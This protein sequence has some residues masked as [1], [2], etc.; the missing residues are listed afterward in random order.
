MTR[1][2]RCTRILEYSN[3]GVRS[4]LAGY[5]A[6]RRAC[7]WVLAR[8]SSSTDRC[9]RC[10]ADRLLRRAVA[11]CS[12]LQVRWRRCSA[13]CWAWRGCAAASSAGRCRSRPARRTRS[14]ATRPSCCSAC[15][16]ARERH[17]AA[18][19]LPAEE[20]RHR[21]VGTE[22]A[23]S[24][25]KAVTVWQAVGVHLGALLREVRVAAVLGEVRRR[26]PAVLRPVQRSSRVQRSDAARWWI[27]A[28]LAGTLAKQSPLPQP[29]ARLPSLLPP[30]RSGLRVACLCSPYA[31]AA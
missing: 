26:V 11:R 4:L 16:V 18:R 31:H 30:T 7:V 13:G 12:L 28:A 29:P 15:A 10:G 5:Q 3:H 19:P 27:G 22:L 9:E 14:N 17:A 1:A 23:G 20:G 24:S 2:V 8:S 25:D 6:A 21:K